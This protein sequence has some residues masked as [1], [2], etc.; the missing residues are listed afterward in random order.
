[1]RIFF[2]FLFILNSLTVLQ[3]QKLLSP[4]EFLGY[5][6][7]DRFTPSHE[8]YSYFRQLEDNSNRIKIKKYGESYEGR[9]LMLAFVSSEENIK[10]LDLVK[11]RVYNQKTNPKPPQW[12]DL[13]RIPLIIWMSYGVHGDEASPTETSMQLAYELILGEF[14][15]I[16]NNVIVIIDPCLNPDGHDRYV[17]WYHSVK[18][19]SPQINPLSI[20]HQHAW[21]GGRGNHYL[22]DLNRDWLWATQIETQTRLKEYH[23]WMPHVH[24]DF[25]E[26]GVNEHYYFPPAAEPYHSLIT[27]FQ[28]EFQTLLGERLGEVFDFNN[29]EYYS[30]L[31]FDLFYP[32]FGDTYPSF[33]GA[34]GMTFEQAGKG[35]GVLIQ[36]KDVELSLA[37]RIKHHLVTSEEVLKFCAGN[38]KNLKYHFYKYLTNSIN[39]N[40]YEWDY[41]VINGSDDVHAVERLLDFHGIQHFRTG[42]QLIELYNSRSYQK[43][44]VQLGFNS[45]VIPLNTSS[46]PLV[47]ILFEIEPKL[48]DSLTYDIT[49]W[50]LAH[51]YGLDVYLGKGQ[52]PSTRPDKLGINFINKNMIAW[53][54]QWRNPRDR[55]NIALNI[56]EG[57]KG[58]L[59]LEE[60][61][62]DEK[63]VGIGSVLFMKSDNPDFWDV[64]DV[65]TI[66][67]D[68]DNWH[69]AS[70]KRKMPEDDFSASIYS[71]FGGLK[72]IHGLSKLRDIYAP[73]ILLVRG[74]GVNQ[75]QFGSTWHYL[76]Q[77]LKLN[78]LIIEWNKLNDKVLNDVNTLIL[79]GEKIDFS[80]DQW[81]SIENW[82]SNG[83]HLI[84]IGKG[85]QML[86]EQD[87]SSLTP[88]EVPRFESNKFNEKKYK[89]H[90]RRKLSYQVKGAIIETQSDTTHPLFIGIHTDYWTLKNSTDL[91]EPLTKGWNVSVVKEDYR[92]YGFVGH[93]VSKSLD[94]SL[95]IGT[96]KYGNG[97]LTYFVDDPLFRGFWNVG[98]QLILNAIYLL[99]N[100]E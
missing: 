90:K 38:R 45:L 20:E 18:N 44:D 11:E 86:A 59:L 98:E 58:K 43:E 77:E 9:D 34:I 23:R 40:I 71:S 24:C 13:N 32:G 1:M 48:E 22:F 85:N 46:A 79:T 72:G 15:S 17:N 4:D 74:S 81:K 76:E 35:K 93:E 54:Y 78:P 65:D 2:L 96:E 51:A 31:D 55:R 30:K 7:G 84:A 89:D 82:V 62:E 92:K 91:Y 69:L 52:A 5:Q 88:R 95:V 68:F 27:D 56:S 3:S 50:S 97:R 64:L 61:S 49:A 19:N 100:S 28:L 66:S 67:I 42:Y 39:N 33:N 25:H 53:H 47:R 12:W 8:V 57:W 14:D 29:W 80:F 10:K 87:F 41:V 63:N 83:G 21:P 37:G 16:L 26:M 99:P 60:Q 36:D 94:N 70:H 75:Y 6:L 73:K